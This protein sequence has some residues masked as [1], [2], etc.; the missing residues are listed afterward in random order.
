MRIRN[1]MKQH[2]GILFPE[3][4]FPCRKR[5]RCKSDLAGRLQSAASAGCR[6]TLWT[7]S[8]P[9][10]VFVCFLPQG[11]PPPRQCPT[12]HWCSRALKRGKRKRE[13]K[14]GGGGER[15]FGLLVIKS[16]WWHR[17]ICLRHFWA[18]PGAVYTWQL[19]ILSCLHCLNSGQWH[20][21]EIFES[22]FGNP[23]LTFL[24]ETKK[25]GREG[26]TP[27]YIREVGIY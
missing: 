2:A 8:R 18:V 19:D 14:E 7:W 17:L 16:S 26:I 20:N 25:R 13:K 1:N 5:E 15:I 9:L 11:Q 22:G 24:S 3:P 21:R 23:K 12:N 10:P 6:N 27:R 4:D